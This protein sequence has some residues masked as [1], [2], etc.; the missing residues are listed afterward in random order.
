M[1]DE[2]REAVTDGPEILLEW[3][4]RQVRP[5]VLL[6]LALISLGSMAVVWFAV[7]TPEAVT[8]LLAAG[9]T[10]LG[11]TAPSVLNR[12]GYRATADSLE[13]LPP[14]KRKK[15]EFV[16]VCRWDDLSH[17]APGKHNI[18]YYKHLNE[19]NALL[20]FWKLHISDGYSGE[21][22][23]E[24]EDRD[25]ILALLGRLGVATEQPDSEIHQI[26]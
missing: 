18:K 22:H 21:I 6:W 3:S 20:R 7:H 26:T 14:S 12:I 17:V 10:A 15:R 11:T 2:T 8:A 1:G 16:T 23:M 13:K 5:V 25:E 4:A 24:T 9:V 19:S